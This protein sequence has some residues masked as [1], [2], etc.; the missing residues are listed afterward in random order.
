M[1]KFLRKCPGLPKEA[2][3]AFLG[4]N[5]KDKPEYEWDSVEFHKNV[6]EHYVKSFEQSNQ[7]GVTVSRKSDHHII[8]AEYFDLYENFPV[9]VST[10]W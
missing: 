10:S 3:G 4:E 1:A 9:G 7:V 5:G 6:L 2:V 8:C